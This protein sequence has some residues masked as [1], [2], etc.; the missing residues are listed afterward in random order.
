[1]STRLVSLMVAPAAFRADAD[2]HPT[3]SGPGPSP[4]P[5]WATWVAKPAHYGSRRHGAGDV[6]GD[7]YDDLLVGAERTTTARWMRDES[8][9]LYGSATGLADTQ[10]ER[11]EQRGW[12]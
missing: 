2:A 12:R 4:A 10:L 3:P 5:D 11:R 6:N 7:G 8:I 9:C 1:M